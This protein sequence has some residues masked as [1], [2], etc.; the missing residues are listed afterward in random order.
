MKEVEFTSE[1]VILLLN[2]KLE[3]KSAPNIE[4]AYKNFDETY[5]YRT[6]A[7]RRFRTVMDCIDTNFGSYSPDFVFYKQTVI[8]VF[9]AAVYDLLFGLGSSIS[10]T[11]SNQITTEQISQIK[12]ASERIKMRT[13]PDHVLAASD[14]RT[15]NPKERRELFDY[16]MQM[17]REDG[18]ANK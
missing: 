9:F 14:R 10:S 12:L 3:G 11:K 16:L 18:K 6:Q 5:P 2:Q 7:E 17:V 8:Y 4:R 15:T 1:L 13:A